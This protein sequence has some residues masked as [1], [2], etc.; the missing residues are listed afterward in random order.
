MCRDLTGHV[1]GWRAGT[2]PRHTQR[3]S[4]PRPSLRSLSARLLFTNYLDND[5]NSSN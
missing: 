3:F 4:Q 2:I 1:P 5:E